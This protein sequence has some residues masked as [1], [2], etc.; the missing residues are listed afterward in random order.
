MIKYYID[1]R[2]ADGEDCEPVVGYIVSYTETIK[3]IATS[4]R[5]HENFGYV[6]CDI[7]KFSPYKAIYGI[8]IDEFGWYSIIPEETLLDFLIHGDIIPC[9]REE[10]PF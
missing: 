2:L 5:K 8:A 1:S 7:P 10:L 6:Y 4:L 9:S 3:R